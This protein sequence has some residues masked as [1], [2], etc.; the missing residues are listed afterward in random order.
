MHACSHHDLADI[1]CM[2]T[3]R[4]YPRDKMDSVV[5]GDLEL[6]ISASRLKP[7][8]IACIEKTY[9]FNDVEKLEIGEHT[10]ID[11]LL[12]FIVIWIGSYVS[13]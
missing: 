12:N 1:P 6:H 7:H 2:F 5:P 11:A 13:F 4:N 8:A 10:L 3:V 9:L